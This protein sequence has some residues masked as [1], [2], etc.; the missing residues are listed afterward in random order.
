MIEIIS[1]HIFIFFLVFLLIILVIVIWI[2]NYISIKVEKLTKERVS[3]ALKVKEKAHRIQTQYDS[4]SVVHTHQGPKK[5]SRKYQKVTVLF[6]DIQGFTRIVEQLNPEML[7]DELDQFFLQFDEIV[8]KYDIE[9]IK[10][11]GDAYM[12]AG[13]LPLKNSTNPVEVVLAAIEMQNFMEEMRRLKV[14][15]HKEYWELRIGIHTGPVISGMVGRKKISFDIWGDTVNIASRM[16]SSGIAGEINISGITWQLVNEFFQGEHR[17][18]MPIKYKGETDMYFIRGII[19]ELSINGEGKEPNELFRIKLQ[20]IRFVDMEEAI[21]NRLESE[22]SDDLTYHN[23]KHTVDVVTQVE[24]IGK[25]ENISEEEMLLLKA[26]ALFH[27]SGFL[28]AYENH[29]DNSIE[30]AREIL[31]MYGFQNDQIEEITSLINVTRKNAKPRSH[32]EAIL[33]DADLDYLGRSDFIPVSRNLYHEIQT[34][35]GKMTIDEWN[36]KQISF[37]SNHRYY[38]NTAKNL[39]QVKKEKQLNALRDL[40]DN[41]S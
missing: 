32:L 36:R 7:I 18:K 21:L 15:E 5:R 30:L 28:I 35:N 37:I 41:Q 17:G 31:Q 4:E 9:K 38:T 29:E 10:T 11:I 26:A 25:G 34:F 3:L 27:D 40:M 6:A 24:I 20:H 39:R 2:R 22:L 12:C 14:I 23:M 33:K 19:P 16:E 1:N 8:E 13:G